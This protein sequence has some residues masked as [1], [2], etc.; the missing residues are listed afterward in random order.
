[1][2]EIKKFVENVDQFKELVLYISEKCG[3]DNSFDSLVLSKV[4]FFSDFLAYAH[5][6]APITGSE[7][8]KMEKG[9]APRRIKEIKN[10]MVDTDRTLGLQTLPM[11][12]W[13]RPVSLR[14]PDLSKFSASQIALVDHVIDA[15]KGTDGEKISEYTHDWLCWKMM[16]SMGEVIPYEMI[17]LSHEEPTPADIERGLAVAGELGLLERSVV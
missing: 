8:V 2:R 16:H 15:I 13:K 12:D 9:P 5:L 3:S 11:R 6:G 1:M 4:L 10:Q 7:Y 14:K 17:F